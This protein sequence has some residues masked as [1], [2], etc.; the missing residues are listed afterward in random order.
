VITIG[1]LLLLLLDI[2]VIYLILSG[3]GDIVKMG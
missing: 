1:A 2:Y 3:A